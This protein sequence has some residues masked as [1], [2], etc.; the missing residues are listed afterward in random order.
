MLG[1]VSE[2]LFYNEILEL[3]CPFCTD[4]FLKNIYLFI[5]GGEWTQEEGERESQVE[6]LTEYGDSALSMEP[7]VGLDLMTLR[8]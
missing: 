2:Y 5:L 7:N 1:Y 3:M 8:S 6:I 4:K